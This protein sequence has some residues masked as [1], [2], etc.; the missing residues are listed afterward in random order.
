MSYLSEQKTELRQAQVAEALFRL[1]KLKVHPNV[2]N[3][4]KKDGTLNSST[5]GILFWLEEHEKEIVKNFEEKFNAVV[6]HII[7]NFTEFGTMYS[8][9]YVTSEQ[10][11][12]EE[13]DEM[14][15]NGQTIACVTDGYFTDL[16]TIGVKP[17]I[18]GI[19]RTF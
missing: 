19:V 1:T 10:E 8:M 12:W 5:Q 7:K 3:D 11:V 4:F 18:G 13:D 15:D 14:L 2:I 16:G 9:L 6:Y 17:F